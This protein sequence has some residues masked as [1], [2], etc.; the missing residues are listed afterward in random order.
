MEGIFIVRGLVVVV[1]LVVLL[2][3]FKYLFCVSFSIEMLVLDFEIKCVF[4]CFFYELI[5]FLIIG[6]CCL[7]DSVVELIKCLNGL[8]IFSSVFVGSNFGS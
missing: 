7:G 3:E 1:E 5:V 8:G 4:W 2:I 6:L